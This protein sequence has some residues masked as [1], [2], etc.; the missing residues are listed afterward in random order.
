MDYEKF[1][2]TDHHKCVSSLSSVTTV[3][4]GIVPTLRW[5]QLVLG[6]VTV[7][8]Q[9]YHL[10]MYQPTRLTRPCLQDH[11]IEYQF[12]LAGVKARISPLSGDR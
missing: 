3:A 11:L 7:F 4:V 6:L 8:G 5:V 10:G 2:F 9:V 12:N 1:H